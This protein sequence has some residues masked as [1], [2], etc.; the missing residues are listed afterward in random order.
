MMN[1]I[2]PGTQIFLNVISFMYSVHSGKSIVKLFILTNQPSPPG[3]VV[4]TLWETRV[5]KLIVILIYFMLT[6][7]ILGLLTDT[8]RYLNSTRIL[9]K[10]GLQE[11]CY[12]QLND[13]VNVLKDQNSGL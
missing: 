3:K 11:I 13:V 12:P 10:S 9:L 8:T 5:S 6:N 1:L 2:F 7:P 4:I